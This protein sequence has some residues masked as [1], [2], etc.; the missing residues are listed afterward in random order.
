MSTITFITNSSI[1]SVIKTLGLCESWEGWDYSAKGEFL[2][3]VPNEELDE[4]LAQLRKVPMTGLRING[5]K[6]K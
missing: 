2:L 4:W 3:P 5:K 1:P 6:V